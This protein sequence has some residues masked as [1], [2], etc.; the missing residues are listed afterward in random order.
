MKPGAMKLYF[1]TS[2]VAGA[3]KELSVKGAKVDKIKND[4]FGP[5]LVQLTRNSNCHRRNE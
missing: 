2:D 4:L 5:G 1:A 3:H